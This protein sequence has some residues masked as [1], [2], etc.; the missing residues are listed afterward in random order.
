MT[1]TPRQA[2]AYLDFI[3]SLRTWTVRTAL[4][5][6]TLGAQGDQKAH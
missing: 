3:G 6:A 2:Y 4:M 5:I 1:L